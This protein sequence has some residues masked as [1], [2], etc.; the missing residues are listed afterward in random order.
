MGTATTPLPTLQEWFTGLSQTDQVRFLLLV[1][2]ELTVVARH[3][4]VPQAEGFTDS[5][6]VRHVNEIQ[7]RVAAH[8]SAILTD[9]AA[10]A[11]PVAYGFLVECP[12]R[13]GLR[14]LVASAVSRAAAWVSPPAKEA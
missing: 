5:E 11:D 10:G 1:A 2:H 13:G 7:H 3:F 9:P 14:G 8:A 6:A 12:D 4:Y